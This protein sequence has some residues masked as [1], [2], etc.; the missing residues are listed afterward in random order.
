MTARDFFTLQVPEEWNR[1]LAEEEARG[2]DR[3]AQ[4][5]AAAFELQVR[6][7]GEGGGHFHLQ[8]DEG[9]MSAQSDSGEEP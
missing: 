8:V 4:L 9:R 3:L 6:V 5:R 7:E 2:G 1:R